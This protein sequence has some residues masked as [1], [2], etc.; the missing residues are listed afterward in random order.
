LEI[1]RERAALV[2]GKLTVEDNAPHGTVV[3]VRLES[4]GASSTEASTAPDTLL[5]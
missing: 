1:M 3:S 5:A 2:S 4:H